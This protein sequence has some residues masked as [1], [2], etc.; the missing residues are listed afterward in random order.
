MSGKD[1]HVGERMGALSGAIFLIGLAALFYLDLFWPGILLLI[2]LTAA[3]AV[4]AEEG[5][6]MGLWI[7]AQMTL[8]LGGLPLLIV[9]GLIWPGVLVL[10]GMSA[11]LAALRPPSRP[12]YQPGMKLKRKR[13]RPLD[14]GELPLPDT[15][16]L[17]LPDWWSGDTEAVA[18]DGESDSAP[19]SR[20]SHRR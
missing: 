17:P 20:Q 10:F 6:R 18:E 1:S 16:E 7:L 14:D 8:Y 4:L 19:G 2:W 3:P 13:G 15:D 12:A 11:L 5:W 9:S